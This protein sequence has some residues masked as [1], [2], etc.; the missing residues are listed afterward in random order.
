MA[1]I[2]SRFV[3]TP[4]VVAAFG[5]RAERFAPYLSATDPLAD[6][7]VAWFAKVGRARGWA[8]FERALDHGIDALPS[9]DRSEPLRALFAQIDHP[10]FWVDHGAIDRAGDVLLRTGYFGGVVLG[11]KSLV[12]GYASPG[13]NKPLVMSG[14][15]VDRA[16]RRLNETA[17]FVQATCLAGGLRRNADGLKIT[18][19]VRLM[20][21]QVRAMILRSGSWKPDLWG[22]PIN[23]HDMA[24]TT[25][26]FSYVL[27]EGI[28]QLG[29]HVTAEESERYIQLWRYGG[30]LIGVDPDLLPSNE[31]EALRQLNLIK[32]TQGEP[33]D[34]SRALTHALLNAGAR[35]AKT[36]RERRAAQRYS[37]V[38]HG[39]CR[40]LI[41]HDLA[42]KLG[43]PSNVFRDVVPAVRRTVASVELARSRSARLNQTAIEVG[44]KYWQQLLDVGLG[45]QPAEFHPPQRL[46]IDRDD[47]RL[48]AS[49]SR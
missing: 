13:G 27:L 35:A 45:T 37:H 16:A 42:D 19:K 31:H 28:R 18:V 38:V 17:R 40:G 1:S 9:E 22:A 46:V 6:D 43:I 8:A 24:A 3:L 4:E 23:Q 44:M 20:H 26:L 36:D 41:G 7:V 48:S 39:L 29:F 21:A 12:L 10:P 33:D 32:A 15:L 5:D 14:Q 2:P 25:G 34:D 49:V 11:V 30:W 47:E